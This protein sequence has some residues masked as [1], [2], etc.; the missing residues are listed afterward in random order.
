MLGGRSV[1]D[2]RVEAC[3][4]MSSSETMLVNITCSTTKHPA[5]GRFVWV[6]GDWVLVG[7][8]RQRPGS[9]VPSSDAQQ[10]RSGSFL[11]GHDY[12][13]CPSC[14]SDGF[15]RCNNCA[16]LGCWDGSWEMFTCPRCGTSGT[17]GGVVDSLTTLGGG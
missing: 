6:E 1:E 13:G 15:A 5:V 9:V 4:P 12:H 3:R 17:I 10:S 14:G 7:L 16:E 8:S 11:L 2:N